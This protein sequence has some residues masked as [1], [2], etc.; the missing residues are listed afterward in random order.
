MRNIAKTAFF[1]KVYESFVAEWLMRVIKPYF[2]PGQCGVKGLSTT[3]YLIKF[4]DFIHRN[5]DKKNPHAVLAA[6][7]GL[8]KAFN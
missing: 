7:V 1:S 8:K 5:L 4:L 2:D 3:H 6:F